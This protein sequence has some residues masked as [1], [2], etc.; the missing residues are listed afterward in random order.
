MRKF[1]KLHVLLVFF[2]LL[3]PMAT[4]FADNDAR[5]YIPLPAGTTLIATYF[6]HISATDAYSNG[7]TVSKDTNLNANIGIFRAVYYTKLGNFTVDPQILLPFGEQSL[8]GSG[9][10]GVELSSSGLADPILTATLWLVNDP[11][12]KTWFGF[13][14]FITMPLGE[15]DKEHGLNLGKNRWAFKPEFGFVKG[16]GPKLFLDLTAACEF[17][18]DNDDYTS[19]SLTLEQ[20][21][22]YTAEIHLSYNFT[23]SFFASTDY[24]YYKG[25]ET[26]VQ[27]VDQDDET[28]THALQLSMGFM[29]SPAYQLIV[30]YKN[31]VSVENGL[32]TKT[33][34][35]RLAHFF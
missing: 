33:F 17:Y 18:S 21:P 26:S 35:V 2:I 14:P 6:N 5:D 22:L 7:D 32:K 3:M 12:A 11:E 25:G 19:A 1:T 28:D 24:F 10:G 34:G 8:D 30:K 9:V 4:A 29:L 15:Y 31:D 23:D 16:F 27:G 13:T 20:D